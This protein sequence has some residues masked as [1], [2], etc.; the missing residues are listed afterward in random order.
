M[1]IIQGNQ[2]NESVVSDPIVVSP[3]I[4]TDAQEKQLPQSQVNKIVQHEKSKIE[5]K[6]QRQLA[7][8]QAQQQETQQQQT[9]RPNP[10]S[11]NPNLDM[12]EVYQ[13]VRDK[14]S[15]EIEQKQREA[16][17]S[18]TVNA[19]FSK[20][21]QGKEAYADFEEV[22][23]DFDPAAFPQLA[24]LS[25]QLDNTADIIYE[26]AANPSKLV[27]LD[28]LATRNPRQAQAELLKLSKS[29]GLNKQ[30]QTDS[31]ARYTPA[32]LARLQPSKV[33][34]SNGKMEIRDLRAQGWLKG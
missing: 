1:D 27:T 21:A 25:A 15:A 8:L 5:E 33:S 3:A 6:Y 23:K 28:T 29:I 13:Q 2:G 17:A 20:M 16:K 30:A 32:P 11:T 9:Q 19:Y 7:A 34:G 14:L 22:T 31:E 26:L 10:S 4:E 12:D 24:A 18:Q